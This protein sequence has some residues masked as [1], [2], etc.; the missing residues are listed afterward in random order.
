MCSMALIHS[1][2][3]MVV[4]D[5]KNKAS[6]PGCGGLYVGGSSVYEPSEVHKHNSVKTR[7]RISETGI[8]VRA[9]NVRE[10]AR[11]DEGLSVKTYGLHWRKELNWKFLAFEWVEKD[12][13]KGKGRKAEGRK[14][15]TEVEVL[16][17]GV[18][19]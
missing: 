18:H 17:H 3:G 13:G 19:A 7:T 12:E 4:I 10:Q 1:R 16:G 2:I 9:E 14:W 6:K 8:D 15:K 11:I 5:A